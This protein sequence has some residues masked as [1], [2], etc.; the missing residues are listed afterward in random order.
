MLSFITDRLHEH[1]YGTVTEPGSVFGP[2][3]GDPLSVTPSRE[4]VV[5][6]CNRDFLPADSPAHCL[7]VRPPIPSLLLF[8][9]VL[10]WPHL[11][12]DTPQTPPLLAAASKLR[13][14]VKPTAVAKHGP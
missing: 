8:C 5:P 11:R 1:P 9:G 14:S 6:V 2:I 13:P 10:S 4:R 7:G 12:P 3:T